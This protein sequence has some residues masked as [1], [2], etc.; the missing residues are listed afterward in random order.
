MQH[1]A[2]AD[3]PLMPPPPYSVDILHR[4]TRLY[5]QARVTPRPAGANNTSRTSFLP[6]DFFILPPLSPSLLTMKPNQ[7]T[8]SPSPPPPSPPS[9]PQAFRQ[10]LHT[11]TSPAARHPGLGPRPGCHTRALAVAVRI[12]PPF[13]AVHTPPL[14]AAAVCTPQQSL[15]PTPMMKPPRRRTAPPQKAAATAD[16]AGHT[17]LPLPP[18]S[19]PLLPLMPPLAP[20]P[21]PS[22]SARLRGG[23]ARRMRETRMAVRVGCWGRR[24]SRGRGRPAPGRFGPRRG[25]RR[26][27]TS[28]GG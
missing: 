12:R 15:L 27:G 28:G 11:T 2:V 13:V 3:P 7:P 24:L 22:P 1:L 26:G 17:P 6:F 8:P 18:R 14:G 16:R 25:G 21:S 23:M 20:P 9:S 5:M 4:D 19:Q 10:T